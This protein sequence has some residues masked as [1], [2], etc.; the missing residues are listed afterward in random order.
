[1]Q[2]PGIDATPNL[3]LSIQ[4]FQYGTL[5]PKYYLKEDK[6]IKILRVPIFNTP[7]IVTPMVLAQH[8]FDTPTKSTLQGD[9]F[10]HKG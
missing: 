5:F 1:M 8:E 2:S 4:V 10:G 6:R 9:D 3:K 7:Y